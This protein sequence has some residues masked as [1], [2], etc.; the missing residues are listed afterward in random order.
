MRATV[1]DA[2]STSGGGDRVISN[3]WDSVAPLLLPLDKDHQIDFPPTVTSVI[4]DVGA[5]KSDYLNDYFLLDNKTALIL[6][7]PMPESYIPLMGRVAAV[8]ETNAQP[9]Q[10]DP[11]WKNKAMVLRVAV[12]DEEGVLPFN[13][14]PDPSCGSLLETKPDN[15][16]WCHNTVSSIQTLVIRLDRILKLFPKRIQNI[17]LKVDAEGADL[18]VLMGAGDFLTQLDTVIIECIA[19]NVTFSTHIGECKT[20]AAIEYMRARG[21]KDWMQMQGEDM[22]NLMFAPRNR[23]IT[24]PLAL[25]HPHMEFA[26][27]YNRWW[28]KVSEEQMQQR[29]YQPLIEGK[30]R[31][32]RT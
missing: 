27:F 7:D 32:R 3:W 19:P 5:R 23:T 26:T 20:D 11:L 12:S 9:S 21:F 18:K 28:D 31:M 14:A 29:N 13:V 17:N 16:F 15:P 22:V 1:A 2:T 8:A 10:L 25:Q 4:I 6:V 30:Q 24:L